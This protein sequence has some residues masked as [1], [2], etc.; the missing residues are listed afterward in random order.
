MLVSLEE[1]KKYLRVDYDDDDRLIEEL[2][3]SSICLCMNI[4]RIDNETVF[5]QEKCSK[6]AVLYAV[7]YLYEHRENANHKQLVNSLKTL[8]SSMRKEDF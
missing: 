2:I 4:A 3:K 6:I 1:M 8:L 7:A 5:E